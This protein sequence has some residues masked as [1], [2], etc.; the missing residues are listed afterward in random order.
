MRVGGEIGEAWVADGSVETA[1][2][3]DEFTSMLHAEEHFATSFIVIASGGQN[4]FD[5]TRIGTFV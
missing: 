1:I 2:E 3:A 5:G 4:V